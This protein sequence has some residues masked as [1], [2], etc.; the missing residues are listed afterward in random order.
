MKRCQYLGISI[1]KM[2]IV[3]TE[4][5][6][7]HVEKTY[8]R[9]MQTAASGIGGLKLKS[10]KRYHLQGLLPIVN[11]KE[12]SLLMQVGPRFPGIP[13][14]RLEFNPAVLGREGM[15]QV[16]TFLNKHFDCG[17]Q[18]LF[19]NGKI[20]RLDIAV[21]L[22]GYSLDKVVVRN[23]G[24]RV[25]GV[26]TGQTGEIE[27]TYLGSVKSNRTTVYTKISDED[28][29]SF[30][31]LERRLIPKCRGDELSAMLNPFDKVRMISIE[32]LE[33]Y[34]GGMIPRQFHDSVRV[35]GF[36]HSISDLPKDQ[37][38]KIKAV[39]LDP[40]NS[41]LPSIEEVWAGW[42]DLLIRS[43]LGRLCISP[44]SQLAAE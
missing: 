33:P 16:E 22:A 28:D 44:T 18:F 11:G 15:F 19:K 9:L 8:N 26:Y 39:L 31:R 13:D 20:T 29:S 5:D 35:R 24:S 27:T 30:L 42:P 3:C 21:D 14:H 1:D 41:L 23:S 36:G 40:A 10:G 38:R 32:T 43:G 6:P 25:H 7:N 34:L 17:A 37:R 12:G 2:S 4:V